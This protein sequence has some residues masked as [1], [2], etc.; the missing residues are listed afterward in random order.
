MD[1]S[2]LGKKHPV[3][4]IGFPGFGMAG[5]IALQHVVDANKPALLGHLSL[6][7]QSSTFMAIHEGR[8][9]WPVSAYYDEQR[10]IVYVHALIP[11]L[12]DSVTSDE[13]YEMI[14]SIEP[15]R[16]VVLESIGTMD[17]GHKTFSYT[18]DDRASEGL[19]LP[20][21]LS[22]GVILGT[23]ADL[24]SRYPDRT[25]GLFSEANVSIPDS[26]AAAQ[27]L[28]VLNGLFDLGLDTEALRE[29]SKVFEERVKK[30]L[31]DSKSAKTMTEK[32][33]MFYVG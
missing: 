5:S 21:R 19:S 1:I 4:V 17:D 33:Q 29:M 25:I 8:P 11:V 24:F 26:E 15:E 23:S 14:D 7:D 32:N 2:S 3:L 31:K 9:V 20:E 27:L 6:H 22:E 13:L 16:I 30:I 18:V 28:E 12:N 10:A